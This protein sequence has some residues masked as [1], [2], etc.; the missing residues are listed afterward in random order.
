M[1]AKEETKATFLIAL[2]R[3]AKGEH[4]RAEG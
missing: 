1:Q 3:A 2:K 4:R